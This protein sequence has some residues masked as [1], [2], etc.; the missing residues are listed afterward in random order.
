[1]LWMLPLALWALAT[2]YFGF[3]LGKYSDDWSQSFINPSD[4]S[5]DTAFHPWVRWPFFFRPVYFVVIW[6]INTMFWEHDWARHA[7]AALVH[8]GVGALLFRVLRRIGVSAGAAIGAAAVFLVWPVSGEAV[9]WPAAI[10]LPLGAA[11]LLVACERAAAFARQTPDGRPW[12]RAIELGAWTFLAACF[13]E[14]TAAATAAV[15]ALYLACCPQQQEIVLRVRRAAVAT[16]GC[17]VGCLV[18]IALMRA[19]VPAG[20]RGSGVSLV[21]MGDAPVRLEQFVAR[22]GDW[23]WG[24]RGYEVMVGAG[25][26]GAKLLASG[27]TVWAWGSF[28]VVG[29]VLWVVW[30]ATP[31]SRPVNAGERPAARWAWLVLFGIGFGLVSLAPIAITKSNAVA[32]RYFYVLTLGIAFATAAGAEG[33]AR[34]IASRGHG[35]AGRGLAI[36]A[37]LGTAGLGAWG[38]MG[39]VWWQNAFRERA[40]AD[41]SIG[42]QLRWAVAQPPRDAVIVPVSIA[43]RREPESRVFPEGPVPGALTQPW[44]CWCFVQRT[45]GRGDISATHM[46]PRGVVTVAVVKGGLNYSKALCDAWGR[47]WAERSFIPWERAVPISIDAEGR[48]HVLSRDVAEE[49]LGSRSPSGNAPNMDGGKDGGAD[50]RGGN[51]D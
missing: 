6:T 46:R 9:L 36:A 44:A 30:C 33:L 16:A 23:L 21:S 35:R 15:P 20:R 14:Q 49:I 39:M 25:V 42:T 18:Y 50:G 29:V 40:A 12:W 45:Y 47:E 38:A 10:G 41:A 3:D 2:G 1:M 7:I 24:A 4:G 5:V 51:S 13:H 34:W 27:A 43:R 11:A 8:L 22:A 19:T 31:S 17:G 37:M 26:R 28:V 48:V 32:S